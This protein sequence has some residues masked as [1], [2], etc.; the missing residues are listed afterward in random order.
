MSDEQGHSYPFKSMSPLETSARFKILLIEDQPD[1]TDIVYQA[2]VG[3]P[4]QLISDLT[5]TGGLERAIKEKPDLILLDVMMPG[6]NGYQVC[7]KL[8]EDRRTQ[9]IPIIFLTAMDRMEHVLKGLDAGA[10]DYISKPFDLRELRARVKAVLRTTT[11]K[12]PKKENLS[13]SHL[14]P[15][16]AL[17]NLTQKEIQVLREICHGSTNKE[18]ASLLSVSPFTIKNHI[19]NIFKKLHTSSRTEAARIGIQAHLV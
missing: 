16:S 18:I 10:C 7:A 19:S 11:L 2:F 4:F 5:P 3:E 6:M 12:S 1:L 17:S 9:H 15:C 14:T 8:R 13:T